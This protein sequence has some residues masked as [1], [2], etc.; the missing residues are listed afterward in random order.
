VR[1]MSAQL[2]LADAGSP[3]HTD[4]TRL[5]HST[6]STNQPTPLHLTPMSSYFRGS[7]W[8]RLMWRSGRSRL[9]R[10]LPRLLLLLLRPVEWS[11]AV[12]RA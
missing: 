9:L 12:R 10:L 11:H 8:S 4:D 3:H 1:V 6:V 5:R 7:T 2:L